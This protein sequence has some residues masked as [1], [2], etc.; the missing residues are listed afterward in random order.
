[1]NTKASKAQVI[2]FA[3]ARLEELQDRL[4]KRPSAITQK[5]LVALTHNLSVIKDA[6]ETLFAKVTFAELTQNPE[7]L[8]YV[9]ATKAGNGLAKKDVQL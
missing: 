1:M 5:S 3:T 7:I 9:L 6:D 2:K 8:A 4:D